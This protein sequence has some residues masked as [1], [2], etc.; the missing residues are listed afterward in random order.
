[1]N[2]R[3]RFA[4]IILFGLWLFATAINL[5]KAYHIDDTGHLEAAQWILHN[6]LHP[7]SGKINWDQNADS[8]HLLN[9]PHLYFYLMAAWGSFF[10]FSEVAMHL[11]QSLFTLS[12]IILIYLIA[13]LIISNNALFLTVLLTV[14]PAFVVGQNLMVDVPLLSFCL[15]FYYLLIKPGVKSQ[16]QRL[17]LAGFMAGCACLVKYTGLPLVL[18]MLVYI[19][20]KRQWNLIWTMG[21]PIGMLILW[22]CFNYLDYG[23][24][25]ILGR[26][27]PPFSLSDLWNTVLAWLVGLGS[28]LPYSPL[29][30]GNLWRKRK[31]W[32]LLVQLALILILVSSALIFFG[33]TIGKIDDSITCKYL[34]SLFLGNGI[35]VVLLLLNEFKENLG[36]F[37]REA[38]HSI[39][40]L[41]LW[42]FSGA[43]FII[44]FS[45]FI[46]TRHILL[47]IVPVTLLLAHFIETHLSVFW[48]AVAL[49]LCIFLTLGLGISDRIMANY[50]REKAAL[51]RSE[52]PG[53][54]NIYFTGHWGW[55]WYAKQNGMRQLEALNPQIQAGDYLAYPE[56]IHQQR[57]DKIPAN[58]Q[59][60]VV[61][62]YTQSPSILTF[63]KTDHARFYASSFE[64]LPWVIDRHPFDKIVVYQVQAVEGRQQ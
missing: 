48:S 62:E 37:L 55:Q 2:T 57:L 31:R 35:A 18:V 13:R 22:S 40:I 54:A 9:Q 64:H 58:L 25:H 38:N 46:A 16:T 41:Y 5:N 10:G 12:C 47:V 14:S 52:L 59:L 42:L 33:V 36:D 28:I 19:L 17:V 61:K 63:F 11:F 4:L 26:S 29:F 53:K 60:K 51:I 30:F 21:I 24:I 15:A 23:S 32:H 44:C 43:L 50:Y 6:P 27:S 56:G 20:I 34:Q 39:L 45:P 49:G 8:I 3:T 7:M 1:M